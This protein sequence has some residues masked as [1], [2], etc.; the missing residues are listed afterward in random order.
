MKKILGLDLGTNSIGWALVNEAQNEKETSEIVK[1][2][3]RVNPLSVDEKTDFEKGRPL[4]INADRTLK[5]GARRN[6]QRFKLRRENLIEVLLREKLI[7]NNT[8]LTETANATTF[9]TLAFRAKA[10]NEKIDLEAFARVLLS[11]NKKRGYKS[12]RKAKN[13]DE[14]SLIDG[15]AVAKELYDRQITPGQFVLELLEQEKKYIP[16]FYRSDLKAEFDAVWTFQMQFYPEIFTDEFYKSLEGQGLQNT[17]KRFL[18]IHQIYT[19]ENKGKRDVVKLQHYKWR[20]EALS[21][22]LELPKVAYVLVEINNNLNN[23]SGYL[24]AISDRSKEL[25]F[26]HETVGENLYNQIQKNPHTSLKNQVFYRQDYLDEFEKIWE[27][28]SQF[29]SQLT[30]ELKDE[31]RDV[32]IFYQ[33]KLKS[34][35]HLISTCEFEKHHKVLPKSS[36]LFQ[37]FKIWQ[38]LNNVEFKNLETKETKVLSQED[39]ELLFEEL[40]L[41]GDLNP[42]AVLKLMELPKKLWV[43]NYK[44]S[45]SGNTTNQSLYNVYQEIAENEGYGF[46][47]SKK[48]AKEIKNE[49][50]NIFPLVDINPGILQF[51]SD[52]EGNDFSKQLGYQLWHLLYATEDDVKTKEKDMLLY[53]SS[54]TSLKKNLFNKFGFKPEYGAMLSAIS[55]AQDYGSISARAVKKILPYLKVGHEFSE[56]CSLAGYRHSHH[57]TKEEAAARTLK[58]ALSLLPKNSLRNPVVEKILNQMINVINQ[59]VET[60]GKPDEI[61]VELARELKKSAKER[62]ETTSY[63]NAGKKRHEDIRKILTKDFGI[64]NASRNDIIRYKLYEE[65]SSNGNK[66]LYTNTYIPKE[67]LFSSQIEIEHIIPKAKIFDDSFSNKTLAFSKPNKDKGDST[68]FDFIESY[69]LSDLE[70]YKARV[71]TLYSNKAIGKAKF[72]KLLMK[73]SELPDGFIERDL[74]NSQYIAKKAKQLLLEVFRTVNTTTGKV[75]DKLRED[76]DLINIM[77]ELNLPKYRALGLTEMQERKNGKKIEQIIDWTKRNDHRHHAMDALTVAFTTYNHVNYLNHLNAYRFEK[78]KELFAVRN[79]ITKMYGPENGSKKRKFIPPMVNFRV[80]AKKHIEAIL[81]SF[82]AKNKVVTKNKNK[83]KTNTGIKEVTQL[84][85]RGQLHKETVY[86]GRKNVVVKT[87]K[88]SAKFTLEKIEHVTKPIYKAALLKRLQENNGDP[89]KAFAGLNSLSKKP[90]LLENGKFVP[91]EVKT[92]CFETI[93]TIRKPVNAD[94]FKDLKSLQKVQDLKIREILENRLEEFGGKAKEAFSDLDKNPIWLNKE[95]GI[96]IKRVAISGVSNVETLHHKRDHFGKSLLNE[97]GE[98]IP[99]SFV[100]TGN[101]HHVA[102]YEDSKGKLQEKVVSFYEAVAR[103]NAGLS[104]IDKTLNESLGWRFLFTMKQNEMFVFPSDDFNPFEI[105]LLDTA[106]YNLISPHLFR[107]QKI[108]I[109]NYMFCHHLETKVITSEILKTKKQLSRITYNF[110]QSTEHLKGIIKVRINHLG[111]IVYIGEY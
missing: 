91:N 85:P 40:N 42:D 72:N 92:Q 65:L 79:K 2:G 10:A 75:T 58:D 105:D 31:I 46:D 57:L 62:A 27:T 96:K 89:K 102:I 60:Y 11:I 56:A 111:D 106:N 104:I 99:S 21:K 22:Q 35:K 82:K 17:R 95:K 12:S 48:S 94:N 20:V 110:F 38:V 59:V 80:E 1:L 77:K 23:S 83:I 100:S 26:N 36:P 97:K 87:E 24:G 103:V 45:L 13:E 29:H 18:A 107:V 49:L 76:W 16:D 43:L 32:V 108:A 74:R 69:Y 81:I 67:L 39:K 33:R 84:T 68:A 63:V 15:M 5:R 3:V 88:I 14:G 66:T 50:K 55:F 44:E 53:G 61:R 70:N 93:Y 90:V 64:L 109:K 25:F 8:L 73:E 98:Q 52:I 41:R 37:E 4:T 6:L 86:A 34:Q 78:N 30:K 51:D 28:Q 7:D 101:N 54:N 47:W 71:S 19:A 9:E